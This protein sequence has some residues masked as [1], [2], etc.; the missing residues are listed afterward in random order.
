MAGFRVLAERVLRSRADERNLMMPCLALSLATIIAAATPSVVATPMTHTFTSTMSHS[1]D[2]IGNGV[3]Q[4]GRSPGLAIG[5]VEDG[6]VV[7][8]RGFGNANTARHLPFEASSET[9]VGQISEQFTAGA[10]LLLEQDA[11]LKLDDKVTRYIPELT[12]A[13]DVTIRELLNQTS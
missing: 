3:M 2:T 1:I 10:I 5:V 13:K 12:V 6:R 7:Y 8:A 9:Y 4:D 11:K